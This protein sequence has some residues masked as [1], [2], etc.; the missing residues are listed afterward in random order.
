MFC[1]KSFKY[2]IAALQP[3]KINHLLIYPQTFIADHFLDMTKIV[4]WNV[5]GIR[6]TKNL[7]EIFKDL[8]ADIYCIQETKISKE[9]ITE[10]LAFVDKYYSCF[11]IPK[12]D[13]FRGRSGCATYYL[14][15]ARP[16]RA[17][18]G[19]FDEE[20][21]S[22]EWK[23]HVSN[24]V[25][26]ADPKFDD[27]K[28]LDSEGRVMITH[29]EIK[30]SN[31]TRKLVLINV[32]FPRLDPDKEDRVK[33]KDQ[34]NR[35]LEERVEHHLKDPNSN[36]IVVCDLNIEHK[37]IDTFDPPTED[38]D[39][40]IYR[41]WLTKFLTPKSESRYMVDSFRKIFPNKQRAFTCWPAQIPVSR[42][43]NIGTRIDCIFVDSELS[44]YITKVEHLTHVMGSDHCP[45]YIEFKDLRLIKSK[46][47]P[48]GCTR[49]WPNFTVRQ[50]TL[51]SFFKPKG[52]ASNNHQGA[53]GGAEKLKLPS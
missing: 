48:N 17:E 5:N 29:H 41:L 53:G 3:Q 10:N 52:A 37:R 19:V 33:F 46:D 39:A 30:L 25:N 28:N 45:V 27:I 42:A 31:E 9:Q 1:L 7:G 18:Y 21:C 12:Q 24:L 47:Q 40:D 2:N 51:D 13:G 34:F 43:K 14:D 15:S 4:T 6:S 38:F 44:T 8:K 11:A 49:T 32:Y 23:H 16:Y 26:M 20:S 35:L 22:P 36:V 50:T